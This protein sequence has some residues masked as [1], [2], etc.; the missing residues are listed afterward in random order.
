MPRP[1]LT[2]HQSRMRVYSLFFRAMLPEASR[3]CCILSKE[4]RGGRKK[5][6]QDWTKALRPIGH[7]A[8]PIPYLRKL[9]QLPLSV[10]GD[11]TH[12][13][14][15]GRSQP[16]CDGF[17]G[18]ELPCGSPARPPL[19]PARSWYNQPESGP[20]GRCK[21]RPDICRWSAR[22]RRRSMPA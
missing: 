17:K 8:I 5:V 2:W 3:S 19:P 11:G 21:V 1:K 9:R 14:P 22:I 20:C 10:D 7:N 6:P 18:F 12:G 13:F 4:M 15:S 16:L